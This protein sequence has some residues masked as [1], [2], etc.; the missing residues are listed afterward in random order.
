MYTG[1]IL[2]TYVYFGKH[3]QFLL[4]KYHSCT[5]AATIF[6]YVCNDRDSRPS[7]NL[8]P[9]KWR[10]YTSPTKFTLRKT[11]S[12]RFLDILVR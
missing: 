8:I 10:W 5:F 7:G 4:R 9:R 12:D 6:P 1:W 2:G 11:S 3:V